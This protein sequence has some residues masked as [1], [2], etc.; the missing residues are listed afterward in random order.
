[1]KIVDYA[2]IFVI[3]LMPIVLAVTIDLNSQ[4]KAQNVEAYYKNLI[5][6]AVSDA[7]QEM[8]ELENDDIEIDY[9][10]NN[11]E[12]KKISI[13]AEHA[14]NTF[15]DSLYFNLGISGNKQAES[16]L[17]EYIPATV[18]IDY[19][20]IHTFSKEEF[21]YKD[22]DG[23]TSKVTEHVLKP[24]KYFSY[25]YDL[26]KYCEDTDKS[27][28]S[29]SVDKVKTKIVPG[30]KYNLVFTLSDYI[31]LLE[32]DSSGDYVSYSRYAK[33][34]KDKL[35]PA[36]EIFSLLYNPTKVEVDV[37]QDEL[38]NSLL[39]V[40]KDLI[41]SMV[42]NELSYTI[43]KHNSFAKSLAIEYDFQFSR[44]TVEDWYN[45]VQDVGV[46]SFIQGIALGNNQYLNH[47]AFGGGQLNFSQRYLVTTGTKALTGYDKLYHK[48][49]NCQIY[50]SEQAKK[51]IKPNY[52]TSKYKAA[53]AGYYPCPVCISLSSA[54][55]ME[56]YDDPKITVSGPYLASDKDATNIITKVTAGESIKFVATYHKG[57]KDMTVNLNKDNVIL[58][59]FIGGTRVEEIEPD[60]LGNRQF[61]IIIDN[62]TKYD[63]LDEIKGKKSI[64]IL[65]SSVTDSLGKNAKTINSIDFEI[66]DTKGNPTIAIN[67]A[68]L[69]TA[70]NGDTIEYKVTYKK[71]N[72][73]I[74][75]VNL[76]PN[77]VT[78]NGFT[79]SVRIENIS[80]YEYKV[81]LSNVQNTNNSQPNKYITILGDSVSDEIGGRAVN[82]NSPTFKMLD[83]P[84]TIEISPAST[85]SIRKGQKIS[86]V[87]TYKKGINNIA[88]IELVRGEI[89]MYGFTSDVNIVRLNDTQF[90]VEFNNVDGIVGSGKY[91]II[92]GTS[93]SD[94]RGNNAYDTRS[95]TFTLKAKEPVIYNFNYTGSPQSI[96]LIPGKYKFEVWGA[97]GT[98]SHISYPG[99]G[100]YSSGEITLT[101]GTWLYIYIGETNGYGKK[102]FNGG[103]GTQH[104]WSPNGG[105]ATDIRLQ[106]GAWNDVYGLRSRIIV[107]GGGGAS[108]WNNYV[109]G[110]GGGLIGGD[111]Q[112]IRNS[113]ITGGTQT[114]GGKG[115]YYAG[116]GF[117]GGFGGGGDSRRPAAAVVTMAAAQVTMQ[118]QEEEVHHSY[119][120]MQDVMQ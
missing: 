89:Q 15:L 88:S 85:D 37:R 91:I 54:I 116:F 100:G 112:G 80:K 75:S 9:G 109:G 61:N 92:R 31:T 6:S 95:G 105:G 93:V 10:Y 29:C 73:N 16:L 7:S 34:M 79:A 11:E 87:V 74:A 77:K 47:Y 23:V 48:L 56:R 72:L 39:E 30:T 99:A 65:G 96:Y 90:R 106:G 113:V 98:A 20:G 21:E 94:T 49:E 26:E 114:S 78:L 120:D 24:K 43:S 66:T 27:V 67:T 1:M 107:A 76:L 17:L 33:D 60:A 103:G 68:S 51:D 71:G 38:V 117:G 50:K 53:T 13:N 86:Y 101:N 44:D 35:F 12:N 63:L 14:V 4:I 108:E 104:E 18:V 110:A 41:I 83:S 111:G 57:T 59:N 115:N 55:D 19:N 25:S 69:S 64:S 40:K 32:K 62:L 70:Y 97:S 2:I 82:T 81:I 118:E 102:V 22:K 3:I 58:N 46:I 36:S 28:M 8:K 84:P 52:Y 42:T 119:L 5:D 45:T